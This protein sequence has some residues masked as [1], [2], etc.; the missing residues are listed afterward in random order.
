MSHINYQWASGTIPRNIMQ[1]NM[2]AFCS[3]SAVPQKEDGF[4]HLL[5]KMEAIYPMQGSMEYSVDAPYQF[6]YIY[7]GTLSVSLN[8]TTYTL[9]SGNV[10]LLPA[11][12]ATTLCIEKARCRY[13]HMYLSGQA[14]DE[15]HHL[16]SEPFFYSIE[17]SSVMTL[18]NFLERMDS[19]TAPLV[20]D[21][22][23]LCKTSMWINDLLTEMI[24]FLQNPETKKEAI[25]EYLSEIRM[26]FELH[27]NENY[28]LDDLEDAYSI[29][30]YRICR[31][32]SKYFKES[33]IQFLNHTR[34]KVAKNLLLTTDASVHEIGNMVG[35]ANTNHFI[36]LFKRET[37]ATPLAFKQ[38][39]PV[40]ISELHYL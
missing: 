15:Y 40:S 18:A 24:V 12:G 34:I 30:K 19:L 5:G 27:Y 9:A 39:A 23:F 8:N 3:F 36:N 17:N 35:I 13:F 33:P 25:P 32:F 20:P 2:D 4:L 29:S 10:A 11:T 1:Q 22:L 37:G 28:S 26:M 14:L 7:E 38:D 31:E 6:F 21:F 16:L